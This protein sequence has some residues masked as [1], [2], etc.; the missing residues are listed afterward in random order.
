MSKEFKLSSPLDVAAELR[1]ARHE[2]VQADQLAE[3]AVMR[4]NAVYQ[5]EQ[6]LKD[7]GEET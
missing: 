5:I 1:R 6:V 3:H 7:A 2:A 4:A